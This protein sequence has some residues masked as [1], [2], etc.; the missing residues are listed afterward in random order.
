[1][2]AGAGSGVDELEELTERINKAARTTANTV[3]GD[4]L[5]DWLQPF[6]ENLANNEGDEQKKREQQAAAPFAPASVAAAPT[7]PDVDD[8]LVV[9]EEVIKEHDPD[10]QHGDRKIITTEEVRQHLL[11]HH[12]YRS[13]IHNCIRG[14]G[15]ECDHRRQLEDHVEEIPEYHLDYCFPG[16]KLGQRL[17]IL[18]AVE[19]YS[20]MKKGVVVPSK[21]SK[22][23]YAARMVLELISECGDKDRDVIVKTDQE[24]AI[25]F[26]VDGTFEWR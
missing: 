9:D 11:C 14:R 4:P 6:D 23:M 3:R 1:M 12:P 24:P 10:E 20:R 26:L 16:D 7:T 17:T 22:G 25:K 18:V 19:R 15:Q 2:G 13:C 21:G 5:P 8:E